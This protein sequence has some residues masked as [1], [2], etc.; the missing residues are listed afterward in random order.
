M[1]EK[2]Y[3][4]TL[5]VS[6]QAS[7][8]EIHKSY[9]K[10]AKK[11]HPDRNRGSDSAQAK[12]KEITEA[13]NV[14]S[15]PEK[16]KK[17]DQ[18]RRF[19]QQGGRMG[20]FE[21]I[22]GSPHSHA[23]SRQDA[24]SSAEFGDLFS[25][26]FGEG[27]S[28]GPGFGMKERGRDVHSRIT[29]PFELAAEGGK[30]KVKV[31]R[32]SECTRCG[33]SGAAPG[34][35]S[36]ICPSCGGRGRT[37]TGSG[38]FS[39]SQTCRQCLGRGKI[40]QNPCSMCSGSGVRE[41]ETD[42]EVNIPRGIENG[43][44]LRLKGMGGQGSAGGGPGDLM[45]EINVEKHPHFSRN[46][47]DIHSKLTVEMTEAV[48]GTEK[49]VN[50][51]DGKVKLKIPAGTQP[52]RK[53]RLKGKGIRTKDGRKGDHYVEIRVKIPKKLTQEQKEL[54]DRFASATAG[55]NPKP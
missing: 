42:L 53:L 31:P 52:G 41:I 10:L 16:R 51:I 39:I 15:N 54:L 55:A 12:F 24:F 29:V 37:A 8:E 46:G 4:K 18:L 20:G 49:E 25:S 9:R 11:Y 26:I 45:L 2:D 47:L 30:V 32:T 44:K 5:G 21:D 14:L 50:I 13:Y 7:R 33:G 48:L 34:T 17:Y 43:Q 22:F 36:D 28:A 3:Y 6:K 1:T 38:G 40:I 19:R 35:R 23:D 27:R